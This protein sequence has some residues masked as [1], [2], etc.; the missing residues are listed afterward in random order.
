MAVRKTSEQERFLHPIAKESLLGTYHKN[1][2]GPLPSTQRKYQYIFAVIDAYTKFV[3]LYPAKS[4]STAEALDFL[5]K[6]SATFGNLR[7]IISD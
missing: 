6:Q 4:I 1:H 2:L 5:M 3:W 7:R